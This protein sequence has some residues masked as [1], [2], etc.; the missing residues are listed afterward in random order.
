MRFASA[1]SCMWH[2]HEEL[3]REKIPTGVLGIWRGVYDLRCDEKV[4]AGFRLPD[5]GTSKRHCNIVGRDGDVEEVQN[6]RAVRPMGTKCVKF[7]M[8]IRALC[9]YIT[10]WRPTEMTWRHSDAT[11]EV[12]LLIIYII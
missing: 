5:H 2:G 6:E 10:I 4:P 3:V 9:I 1:S 11:G 12:I 8:A 7:L